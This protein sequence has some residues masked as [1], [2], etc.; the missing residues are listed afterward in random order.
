MG[1]AI[2]T[3][4][5]VLMGVAIGTHVGVLMGVELA[6]SLFSGSRQSVQKMWSLL[7]VKMN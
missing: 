4:I 3:H 5:G 6:R 2:G 7:N 1:V